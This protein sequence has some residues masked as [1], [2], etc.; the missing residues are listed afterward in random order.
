ME[1]LFVSVIQSGIYSTVRIQDGSWKENLASHTKNKHHPQH[2]EKHH[3]P[4]RIM[5]RFSSELF[6]RFR[7][8][9]SQVNCLSSVAAG[10]RTSA[11]PSVT[12]KTREI[13]WGWGHFTKHNKGCKPRLIWRFFPPKKSHYNFQAKITSGRLSVKRKHKDIKFTTKPNREKQKIFTFGICK[14]LL[15]C[16]PLYFLYGETTNI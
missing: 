9:S 5:W 2:K 1:N 8:Q 7:P 11:A 16:F 10:L 15:T 6:R 12:E 3:N 14:C 4:C 13:N